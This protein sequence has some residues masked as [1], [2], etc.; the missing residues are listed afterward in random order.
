MPRRA[1]LVEGAGWAVVRVGGRSSSIAIDS[2]RVEI[3]DLGG[4]RRSFSRI[5]EPR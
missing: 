4:L 5:D 3:V 2:A 1:A